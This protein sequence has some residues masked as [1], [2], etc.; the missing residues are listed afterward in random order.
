MDYT[1]PDHPQE[2]NLDV[3][4]DWDKVR[5]LLSP[6]RLA[7]DPDRSLWRYL[8]LLP[9]ARRPQEATPLRSLGWTPLHSPP[10]LAARHGLAGLF[11]KE[12]GGLPTGSLKDRASAVVVERARHSGRTTVATASSGNAGAALACLAACAGLE[13]VIFV[14][15]DAPEAKVAQLLIYGARVFLV[16]GSYDQ[17][18]DLCLQAS[19]AYGWLCRNTGYNPYTAEGKKT[20]A[21]ELVEQLGWRAPDAVY[22]AVGDGNI[23]AGLYKG[24]SDLVELGWLEQLPRLVGVQAEG[25]PAV[26]DAWRA[27]EEAPRPAQARSL[28][29][30][31]NVGLPR[32]GRRALRAV[33]SSGG[34]V[35]RVSDGEILAAMAE[36]GREGIFVEPA[37]AAAYAGLCQQ[38][39]RGSEVAVILTGSGLKDVAAAR[40][41]AGQPQRLRPELSALEEALRP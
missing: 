26:Y 3:L 27:G 2:G 15:Q 7:A 18:Y 12:E 25:A 19:R 24:L 10:R 29:D 32:D 39:P 9:L 4:Y 28:A 23:L 38:P 17:A 21:L 6:E 37:A 22:V 5:A 35:R 13:A 20:C 11:L 14:P 8:P 1:C 31:I 36:L 33:R 40:R 34:E 30:S 16:E 41:A